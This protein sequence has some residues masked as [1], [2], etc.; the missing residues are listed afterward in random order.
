LELFFDAD[1]EPVAHENPFPVGGAEFERLS[2]SEASGIT[3]VATAA[4]GRGR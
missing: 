4:V 3:R 1:G 2:Y